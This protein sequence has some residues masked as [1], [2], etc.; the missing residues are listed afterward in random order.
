MNKLLT[1]EIID[2]NVLKYFNIQN[3]EDNKN[4]TLE[5]SK[6]NQVDDL[7]STCQCQSIAISSNYIHKHKMSYTS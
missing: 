2:E 3:V 7:Q 4:I 6:I 1:N 5:Y